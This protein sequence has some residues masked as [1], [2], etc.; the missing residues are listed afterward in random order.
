M[1]QLVF[2]FMIIPFVVWVY[3]VIEKLTNWLI[4]RQLSIMSNKLANAYHKYLWRYH[5]IIVIVLITSL[6]ILTL[7]IDPLSPLIPFLL[8][9]PPD[10]L[11]LRNR[12]IPCALHVPYGY[13]CQNGPYDPYDPYGFWAR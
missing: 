9:V 13:Y 5:S 3:L 1:V 4:T 6:F 8:T 2:I 7:L 11:S 12:Y 10:P